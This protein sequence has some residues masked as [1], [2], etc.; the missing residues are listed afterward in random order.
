MLEESRQDQLRYERY[1]VTR[2]EV[3][4][5]RFG[6]VLE[7]GVSYVRDHRRYGLDPVFFW[8]RLYPLL[9]DQLRLELAI[10]R[11]RIEAGILSSTL[12]ALM[13]VLVLGFGHQAHLGWV[14]QTAVVSLC[15]MSSRLAYLGGVHAAVAYS[16]LIKSSFDL[17]RRDL[18][19][20]IGLS[21]PGSLDEER[22]I[23][24]ALGQQLYR[25]GA[26]AEDCLRLRQE[27]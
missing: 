11:A 14:Y 3:T 1:P 22:A 27:P 20:A 7:A 18:L 2:E 12:S 16:E 9:G 23:W 6:N 10:A 24:M 13:A 15:I 26:G 25:R 19:M 17:H 21:L 5:T 8:P 4:A